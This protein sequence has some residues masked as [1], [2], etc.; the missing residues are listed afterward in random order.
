[1]TTTMLGD[2]FVIGNNAEDLRRMSQWLLAS[3]AAADVPKELIG[4]LDYCA[5]EAVYN[6]ISYAYN[7]TDRHE[8]EL[9]LSATATGA[10][11]EIRDD[12]KP[13]DVLAAPEHKQPV[14]LADAKIGGLGIHLIRR[15][16]TRC[17]YKR[18]NGINVL[19]LE[20]QSKR[21]AGNA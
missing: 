21:L 8:I 18:E 2:R 20:A 10:S 11:L 3:G 14:S 4:V 13:F 17:D 9:I 15:L 5:H 1:M 16:I 6:I 7:D 12:G 19:R